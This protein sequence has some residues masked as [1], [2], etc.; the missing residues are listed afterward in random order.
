MKHQQPPG[1][2]ES[3]ASHVGRP[4]LAGVHLLRRAVFEVGRLWDMGSSLNQGPFFG[5][6]II[7]IVRRPYKKQD[8]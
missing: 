6:Q 4:L 3:F 2:V 5:P 7:N 1:S 8:P